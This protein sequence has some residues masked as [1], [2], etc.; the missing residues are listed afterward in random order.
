MQSRATWHVVKQVLGGKKQAVVCCGG[1]I[2]RQASGRQ[3]VDMGCWQRW[4]TALCDE[5]IRRV[6]VVPTLCGVHHVRTS[7]AQGEMI[8]PLDW[9]HACC[10]M[11]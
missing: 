10:T 6:S 5:L 1:G 11:W 2:H 3:E 9:L 7:S 8:A 4:R